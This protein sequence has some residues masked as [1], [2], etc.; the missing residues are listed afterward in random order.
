MTKFISSALALIF[1]GAMLTACNSTSSKGGESAEEKT[2]MTIEER[3]DYFVRA[4]YDAM[5]EDDQKG[6]EKVEHQVGLYVE[7]LS[8]EDQKKFEEIAKMLEKQYEKEYE[9]K[10][11]EKMKERAKREFEE[12]MAKEKAEF[13]EEMEKEK[14]ELEAEFNSSDDF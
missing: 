10:A 4:M 2:E 11:E 13:E 3:A 14:A 7:T 6:L 1:A 8:P 5:V 9:Q 12:E